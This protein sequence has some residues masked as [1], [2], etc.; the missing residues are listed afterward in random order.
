M[1]R[2]ERIQTGHHGK[3]VSDLRTEQVVTNNPDIRT[4]LRS[5]PLGKKPGGLGKG[6]TEIK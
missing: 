4:N 1:S 6:S 3:G 2:E 5:L